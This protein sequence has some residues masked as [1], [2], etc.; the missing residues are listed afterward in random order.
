M[1]EECVT[2]LNPQRVSASRSGV[3]LPNLSHRVTGYEPRLIFTWQTGLGKQ[4][5]EGKMANTKGE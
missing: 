2:P 4:Y 3:L 1:F 5:E